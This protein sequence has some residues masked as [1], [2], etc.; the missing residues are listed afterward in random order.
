MAGSLCLRGDPLR[1]SLARCLGLG[2]LARGLLCGEPLFLGSSR[3]ILRSEA[4]LL[5][6]V[7]S[8][9]LGCLS[10]LRGFAF[11]LG[12]RGF[13]FRLGLRGDSLR[14]SLARGLG[15]GGLA[16]VLGLA[17]GLG[18]GGLAILLGLARG[19]GLGGRLRLGGVALCLQRLEPILFVLGGGRFLGRPLGGIRGGAL[20]LRLAD[21]I[22]LRFLLCRL[23][24]CRLS[25]RL[26]L[27]GRALLLGL[28]LIF[29]LCR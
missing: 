15:L 6:L 1:L 22:G 27:R 23:G 12:L 3:G 13:A 19:L 7:R 21:G 14:L 24:L 10:F 28:A 16:I 2:G 26:C 29:G 11:R 18:L 17:R 8:G 4:T 9:C 25:S 5:S 20:L